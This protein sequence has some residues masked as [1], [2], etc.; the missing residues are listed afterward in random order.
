[1]LITNSIRVVNALT[2][3]Y[4]VCECS[5]T[6]ISQ[7]IPS[8]AYDYNV[9]RGPSWSYT[10]QTFCKWKYVHLL[11]TIWCVTHFIFVLVL[12][13]I[14]HFQKFNPHRRDKDYGIGICLVHGLSYMQRSRYYLAVREITKSSSTFSATNISSNMLWFFQLHDTI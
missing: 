8:N 9:P 4:V 2:Y 3:K 1:M 12:C 14:S 6:C 5:H 13:L 10:M 11:F 7:H